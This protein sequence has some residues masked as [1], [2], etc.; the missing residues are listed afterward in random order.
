MAEQ[1]DLTGDNGAVASDPSP[2]LSG[3]ADLDPVPD[4][5]LIAVDMDGTLLDASDRIDPTL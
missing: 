3:L 5:R 1:P 2:V 4:I